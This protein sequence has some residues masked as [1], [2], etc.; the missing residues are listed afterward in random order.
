LGPDYFWYLSVGWATKDCS[1]HHS[2]PALNPKNT[3]TASTKLS[4]E[5]FLLMPQMQSAG[6]EYSA[7]AQ[8]ISEH[9]SNL[10][11]SQQM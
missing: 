3:N 8:N 7:I 9:T 10:F 2:H 11:D 4:E 1:C 5:D 6:C